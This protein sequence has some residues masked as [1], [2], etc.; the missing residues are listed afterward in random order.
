LSAAA[1]GRSTAPE[2]DPFLKGLP[3]A[4]CGRP[5]EVAETVSFLLSPGAAFISGATITIDGGP[6]VSPT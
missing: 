2:D 4:R 1:G 3:L 5:E 6:T